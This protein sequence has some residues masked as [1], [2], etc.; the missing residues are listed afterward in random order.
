MRGSIKALLP[1]TAL[2]SIRV[3]AFM[4]LREFGLQKPWNSLDSKDIRCSP[5]TALEQ[6]SAHS[7]M[8]AEAL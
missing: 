6:H 4:Q 5:I 1:E 7:G 2:P 8:D 3:V